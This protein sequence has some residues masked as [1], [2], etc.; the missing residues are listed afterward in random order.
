MMTVKKT[1]KRRDWTQLFI[2][3]FINNNGKPSHTKVFSSIAYITATWIVIVLT[4]NHNLTVDYFMWY[5]AI[6]G[7]HA[8]ASKWIDKKVNKDGTDHE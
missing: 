6:V 7:A 3:V 8:T 2:D 1:T 4:Y 5:L